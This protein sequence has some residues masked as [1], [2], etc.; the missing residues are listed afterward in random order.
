MFAFRKS[1]VTAVTVV[2][3]LFGLSPSARAQDRPWWEFEDFESGII[4]SLVHAANVDLVVLRGGG[5]IMVASPP[6]NILSDV[7]VDANFD[8]LFDGVFAGSVAFAEDG[9]GDRAVFWLTITGKVVE[10]GDFDASPSASDLSPSD[11]KG[12]G[13]DVCARYP[14]KPGCGPD[15]DDDDSNDTAPSVLATLCGAG[16]GAAATLSL[17]LLLVGKGRCASRT[18]KSGARIL[19]PHRIEGFS[20][21]GDR[22][23]RV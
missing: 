8:V 2:M 16:T 15:D 20:S 3:S 21:S 14:A 17:G 5:E 13:C 19:R 18:R 1:L 11:I 4:C 23:A 9:D 10:V 6:N 12:T 7:V 22:A